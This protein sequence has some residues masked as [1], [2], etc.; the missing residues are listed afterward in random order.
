METQH[1]LN[2]ANV[3]ATVANGTNA[4]TCVFLDKLDNRGLKN[5]HTNGSLTH[6]ASAKLEQ[7]NIYMIYHACLALDFL[8]HEL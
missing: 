1:Y 3:V 8:D 6:N 4:R 2:H 5:T 7:P